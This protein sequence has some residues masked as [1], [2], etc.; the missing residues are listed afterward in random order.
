MR[1]I[2][3]LTAVFVTLAASAQRRRI[4]EPVFD[5]TP[6]QA[7]ALNDFDKAEEILEAQIAY[8]EATK[9][10]TEEKE[11]LLEIVRKNMLKLHS[12]ACITFVDS[13]V[14]PK[15]KVLDVLNLG[16]ECGTLENFSSYFN[17][18]LA[19]SRI[20]SSN[21]GVRICRFAIFDTAAPMFFTCPLRPYSVAFFKTKGR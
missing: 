13:I 2:L 18:G 6:E 4:K 21:F 7:R 9:Q 3:F 16:S 5:T 12:T 20:S 19:W 17:D 11:A 1:K 15:Q 8:L 14:L 10:D